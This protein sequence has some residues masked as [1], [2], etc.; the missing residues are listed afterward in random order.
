MDK[1]SCTLRLA[2]G[3]VPQ[4]DAVVLACSREIFLLD[5]QDTLVRRLSESYSL[6]FAK[7]LLLPVIILLNQALTISY[8]AF[9]LQQ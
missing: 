3:P 5:I 4:V 6:Q 2:A 1:V 8:G 9:P 7:I